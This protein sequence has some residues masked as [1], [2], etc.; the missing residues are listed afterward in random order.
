[1]K[2]QEL[3]NSPN[4]SAI[5]RLK[6]LVGDEL[7]KVDSVIW[8][9][10]K[11]HVDLIPEMS[12]HTISA[13]G[14]RLRPILTLASAGLCGYEG[15]SHIDIAA[16]VEFIHT[17][18]LMHDDV[19][20]GSKLRRGLLTANNVWGNRESILVGDFLLAK[21]FH[22]MGAAKSLDVYRILS[23]AAVVIS[24]G[25]VLQLSAIDNI[26]NAESWYF[27]V[28]RA[29]TA[30]LFAAACEVSAIL[31]NKSVKERLAL[32]EYGLNLG[33]AFQIVDDALDYS[34][35]QEKLG[36]NIGDDFREGKVTLP[37][38]FAYRNGTDIQKEFWNNAVKSDNNSDEDLALAIEYMTIN[39][40]VN[41]SMEVA[42]QYIAKA[43]ESID[44][45]SDDSVYKKP[46]VDLLDYV[47]QREF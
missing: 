42:K 6:S 45:F 36:K 35:K 5:E 1:M 34:A 33:I 21:A 37:V 12:E 18:T 41:S 38:I 44:I 40:V 25:E 4:I 14:K 29:K 30:E 3:D 24:E 26:E 47:I 28:V 19:V 39:G 15:T 17:A 22:L 13:G 8:S 43:Y 7:E 2:A 16:S 10:V 11:S 46:L 32:R 31:A 20:D 9:Q 27:S 23:N